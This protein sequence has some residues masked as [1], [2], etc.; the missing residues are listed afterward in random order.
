MASRIEVKLEELTAAVYAAE[1][2]SLPVDGATIRLLELYL[3]WLPKSE[4]RRW[5]DDHGE[6]LRRAVFG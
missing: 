2:G 6:R 1:P 4:Q 5:F 3:H